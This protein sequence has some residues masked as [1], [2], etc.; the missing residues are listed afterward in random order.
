MVLSPVLRLAARQARPFAAVAALLVGIALLTACHK[1]VTDPN[2]PK[3]I[4][5]EKGDWTITRGELNKEVDDFIKQKHATREMVGAANMPYVDTG[6]LRRM[7]LKKLLLEKAAT[8]QLQDVDKDTDAQL[9]NAKDSVPPG[10]TLD[11]ELKSAGLTL[12]QLKQQIHDAV[13]VQKVV[14]AEAFKD[15]EPTEQQIDEIYNTHKDAFQVPP[16]IRASRVTPRRTRPRRKS[17]STPRA[18]AS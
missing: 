1:A 9:A 7:V 14:E 5:A 16:M 4:V 6:V 15:V 18:R 2:D 17:R 10:H 8:M 12:D 3:F 13:V 11:D